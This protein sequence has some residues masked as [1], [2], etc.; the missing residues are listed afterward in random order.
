MQILDN[1]LTNFWANQKRP[2]R[3]P[4]IAVQVKNRST[5]RSSLSP[6]GKQRCWRPK[7]NLNDVRRTTSNLIYLPPHFTNIARR[8]A[9]TILFCTASAVFP[10]PTLRRIHQL[11]AQNATTTHSG[12]PSY[13]RPSIMNTAS[14]ELH[15]S[16][17]RT[18]P[19]A[20]TIIHGKTV[21]LAA[22]LHHPMLLC[23]NINSTYTTLGPDDC[24][25]VLLHHSPG[26]L[27]RR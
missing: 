27:F 24:G 6:Q 21:H 9:L 16:R 13:V 22:N 20:F 19:S 2:R 8:A 23:A 10:F 15:Q 14:A 18:Q 3:C 5:E 11:T 17:T 12:L 1:Y 26:I 4:L 7:C 25:R